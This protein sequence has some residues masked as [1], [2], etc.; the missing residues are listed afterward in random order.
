MRRLSIALLVL[1]MA[2]PAH[3]QSGE[4]RWQFTDRPNNPIANDPQIAAAYVFTDAPRGARYGLSLLCQRRGRAL[5]HLKQASPGEMNA[6]EAYDYAES[7]ERVVHAVSR[8][9]RRAIPTFRTLNASQI[10]ALR[11][12][13]RLEVSGGGNRLVFT[14]TGSADAIGRMARACGLRSVRQ[15]FAR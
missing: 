7:F 2:A 10:A 9:G 15:T 13:E 4:E 8:T 3:S 11:N 12:A 5:I 6:G 14:G 1:T